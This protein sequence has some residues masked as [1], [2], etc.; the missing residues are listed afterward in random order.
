ME[1]GIA[2]TPT[3]QVFVRAVFDQATAIHRDDAI[4]AANR[5]KPVG[6]DDHRAA[7][8]D[9][10]HILLDDPLAFVIKCAG[11]LVEN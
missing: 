2:A 1:L 6:N 8:R 3:Q 9:S 5:G 7:R 4:G 11:S 10:S